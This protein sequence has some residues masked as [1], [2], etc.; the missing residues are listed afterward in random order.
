MIEHDDIVNIVCSNW[1]IQSKYMTN[2]LDDL[3][4]SFLEISPIWKL[5]TD[6]LELFDFEF[7]KDDIT[8]G[9]ICFYGTCLFSLVYYG[10]IHNIDER[11]KNLNNGK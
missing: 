7:K 1:F 2:F 5:F 8:S 11:R 10:Y 4:L 3:D 9:S 6:K